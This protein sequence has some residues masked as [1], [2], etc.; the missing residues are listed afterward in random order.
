MSSTP[1][2]AGRF[3]LILGTLTALGPLSIDMYLPALPA[4]QRS[5][6]TSASLTQ[7]TL[8]AFFLGLGLG[9]LAYG[10]LTDRYGRKPPLYVGLAIYTLASLLCAVAP[11][12]ESLIAG[13]FLQAVGGAAGQV[14]T[15]AAVRDRYVGSE[16]AQ[17]LSRLMLVM[18]L[19]PILAP[20]FGGWVLLVGSWRMLF[21]LLA[22]CGTACLAMMV[23]FLPETSVTRTE[24]IDARAIG[25]NLRELVTDRVFM[26]SSLTQAFASAGMFAYIAGSPFVMIE[27]FGVSP[28]RFSVLFGSNAFGLIVGS[29]I[30]HRLLATRTPARVLRGSTTVIALAGLGLLVAASTLGHQGFVPVAMLLFAYVAS[31][32]FVGSNATA[33]AMEAQGHRAGVASALLGAISF[34]VAAGASSLVGVFNDGTPRPMAALMAL[35]GCAS[36]TAASIARRTAPAAQPSA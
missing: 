14:V 28:Q 34:L 31:I 20:V 15:R 35:C 4:I 29:Q 22:V 25:H 16:A 12:V 21:A 10:P 3:A 11:N 26:A 33:I 24:R 36:W 17:L 8:S 23:A 1:L 18:G 27:Y 32:G 7:L 6:H 13:R 19:A 2:T 30:N 5:L 9:Q